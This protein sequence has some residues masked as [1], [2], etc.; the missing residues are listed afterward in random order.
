MKRLIKKASNIN[1]SE[2]LCNWQSRIYTD[3]S[4]V[5]EIISQNPDCI[6][7]GTAYRVMEFNFKDIIDNVSI[8]EEDQENGYILDD[9]IQMGLEK[10]INFD[11]NYVS[12]GKDYKS[13]EDQFF[14]TSGQLIMIE[15][16]IEAL[17]MVKLGEKY[18]EE[19]FKYTILKGFEDLAEIVA[20]MSNKF[21]IAALNDA[22]LNMTE[23]ALDLDGNLFDDY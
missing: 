9:K 7:R 21:R 14:N 6:Y 4:I 20:P 12:W 15:S 3:N 23:M 17:D 2:F 19:K 8:T 1:I 11:N 10:L 22:D 16:S 13:L 18:L 5:E